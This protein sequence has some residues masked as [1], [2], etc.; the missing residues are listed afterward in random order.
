MNQLKPVISVIK[1]KCVNCHKCISVCP[2]KFCNDG[3]GDFVNIDHN[4]CTGCGACI[5]ACPHDARIGIDDFSDFMSALS[6][7]KDVVAIVAPAAAPNFRGKEL[8]L[9]G[10]LKSIGVKA[11]FDVSFGAELTTKSYLNYIK[12]A[13]PK[14][15]IAQPCPAL[16]SY[17]ELYQPDLIPYLSPA[18]SPMAHTVVMIREFFPEYANAKIAVISPC[19]AKRREFD[20]NGRGDFNVTMAS[21]SKYFKEKNINLASYPPTEF[22]NPPA[23]RAVLYST[24][25]GL[26]RTAERFNPKVKNITRKI[27]GQPLMTEYFHEL[28]TSLKENRH[29]PY[30]LIDCLNCEKGCNGGAGTVNQELPLDTLENYV[31]ER[32]YKQRDIWKKKSFSRK[33][34]MKKINKAIDKYWKDDIFTRKYENRDVVANG[35]L[36]IPTE[37]ELQQIYTDMGKREKKDFLDCGACGYST[38][39]DMAIAIFNNKNKKENCH[40]FLLSQVSSLH[41]SFQ[42]EMKSSINNVTNSTLQNLDETR[43]GVNELTRI[44][45]DMSNIVSSSSS[46][47]EEM[48]GNIMSIETT[49]KKS[50]EAV[51]Q[52]D[53]A[54]VAGES[55]LSE[56][57]TLVEKIEEKSQGLEEMSNV[58]Q[59][60]SEQTN[61]LA[62]NAAIEAA[63]AGESG[64]GFAV[65]ADEIRK[66]AENSGTEAK[67]IADVLAEIKKM[68]DDAYEGTVSTKKEFDNILKGSSEVKTM[69][70]E[71]KDAIAEQ[72]NGGKLIL[73]AVSKLKDSEQAVVV[74]SKQLAETEERVR[75]AIRS[76]A[77]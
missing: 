2:S 65:V 72:N 51:E 24:P 29:L 49:I 14:L 15:V 61:L 76:L 23:E 59:Q 16:V 74:A 9:N 12:K 53:I 5:K 67:K 19:Y 10:W 28:S 50:V 77:L 52:L 8:E 60:I 4:L 64:K 32:M 73:Q 36:K 7:K 43:D 26:L 46:A 55:N 21:I 62:M 58:I 75:E 11:V 57:S 48:I 18:D 39:K 6:T 40:H 30:K 3:S 71:I 54:T 47:I 25:G 69:E 66:L 41:D 38:C 70:L 56:V 13:N 63:H 42:A 44:T 33:N 20:E 27:E 17:V 1:E 35:L 34:C 37:M 68:I 31:E 22:T 45:K